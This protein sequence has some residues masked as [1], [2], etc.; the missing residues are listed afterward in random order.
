[1][2]NINLNL[3]IC[4]QALAV[5]EALKRTGV[6]QFP[7]AIQVWPIFNGRERGLC[8]EVRHENNAR[9]ALLLLFGED[10][11]TDDIF[12]QEVVTSRVLRNGPSLDDF[13]EASYNNRAYFSYLDVKAAV[14]HII[15]HR[16][17]HFLEMKGAQQEERKARRA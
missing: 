14:S 5:L 1:M 10:R 4:P 17:P 11:S 9:Q 12:V 15:A 7:A 13:T 3:D 2:S 16:I 6:H 8:L